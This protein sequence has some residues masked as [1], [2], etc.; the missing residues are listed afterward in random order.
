MKGNGK[1]LLTNNLLKSIVNEQS[2]SLHLCVNQDCGVFF[3]TLMVIKGQIISERLFGVL[4]FSQKSNEFV[5][6]VKTNLFVPF[7]GGF[8]DTKSPFKIT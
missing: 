5:V 4:E 2:H 3:E 6:V 1:T 7:L 8:D